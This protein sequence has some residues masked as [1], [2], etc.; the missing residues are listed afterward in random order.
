[1]GKGGGDHGHHGDA[2]HD[3]DFRNKV[4][5]MT[6]FFFFFLR[7]VAYCVCERNNPTIVLLITS[8]SLAGA[9]L[10]HL[11]DQIRAKTGDSHSRIVAGTAIGAFFAT[12]L[13]ADDRNERP[14][15]IAADGDSSDCSVFY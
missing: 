14:L 1:M 8:S 7:S 9:A 6:G 11:E 2:A 3:G 12:I 15:F 10:I 5:S 13:T 4:R